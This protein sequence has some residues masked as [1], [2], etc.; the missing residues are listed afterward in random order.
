MGKKPVKS[1]T[2]RHSGCVVF[3]QGVEALRCS[4]IRT[5]DGVKGLPSVSFNSPKTQ[6]KLE[7]SAA[8][9]ENTIVPVLL[10]PTYVRKES[11]PV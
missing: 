6:Q 9:A 5:W 8:G 1:Q 11:G 3:R 4:G 2:G 7:T 10:Y